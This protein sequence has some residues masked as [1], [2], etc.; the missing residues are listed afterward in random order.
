MV[1]PV[2]TSA[3]DLTVQIGPIKVQ[4]GQVLVGVFHSTDTFLKA[5][6]QKIVAKAEGASCTAVFKGLEPGDYAVSVH[7]DVNDNG[8][9]D[10]N[11]LGIPSEP[12]GFSNDAMG[13]MG[14]PSFY[15]A[16]FSVQAAGHSLQIKLK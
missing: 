5:P 8:K 10:T 13:S 9:L 7:H 15:Q 2:L 14:P 6:L 1:W 3:A 11:F 16:K 12:Y 4:Q